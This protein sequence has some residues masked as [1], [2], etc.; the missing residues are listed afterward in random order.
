M[1]FLKANGIR[2]LVG[3]NDWPRYTECGS[4]QMSFDGCCHFTNTGSQKVSI[5]LKPYGGISPWM[6]TI[7]G[8]G[9]PWSPSYYGDG[10][11]AG[12]QG[13]FQANF[14]P[15]GEVGNAASLERAI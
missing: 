5:G 8:P 7:L 15:N 10:C 4:I 3:K 11:L 9:Q 6:S 12:F 14:S 13:D 2:G 1:A